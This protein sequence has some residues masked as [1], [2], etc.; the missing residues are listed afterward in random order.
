MTYTVS[1]DWGT[2]FPNGEILPTDTGAYHS[3]Q[4]AEAAMDK[5]YTAGWTSTAQKDGKDGTWTFSG[6]SVAVDGNTVT[7]TGTWMFT[8]KPAPVT[9]K[10]PVTPSPAEH[11]VG[12]AEVQTMP[13]RQTDRCSFSMMLR[14]GAPGQRMRCGNV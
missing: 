7:F 10:P 5:T 3:V 12:K 14:A 13:Q 4:D 11:I 8:E 2:E 6:W 1:Y 9:P